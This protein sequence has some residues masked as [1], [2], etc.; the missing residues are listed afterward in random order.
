MMRIKIVFSIFAGIL[1]LNG[2]YSELETRTMYWSREALHTANVFEDSGWTI[3][4][5]FMNI[6]N[7]DI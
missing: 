2:V 3:D 4:G 7:S 5:S 6:P 1:L